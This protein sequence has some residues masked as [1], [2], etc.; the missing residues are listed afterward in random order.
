[1][2]FVENELKVAI[3]QIHI[4]LDSQFV[5]NWI[6]SERPLGAF[7]ENRVK[8]IKTDKDINFPTRCLG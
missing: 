5:L 1:M 6:Q 4:W 7:V 2:K 3:C 8:V